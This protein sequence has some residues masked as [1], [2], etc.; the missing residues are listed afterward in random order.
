[1]PLTEG[2][3]VSL[4]ALADAHPKDGATVF[5]GFAHVCRG[6]GFIE[7]EDLPQHE[8][9][10]GHAADRVVEKDHPPAG[11]QHHLGGGLQSREKG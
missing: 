6:R 4:G 3:D 10:V 1:M 7:T 2:K 5:M 11:M 9:D 8:H